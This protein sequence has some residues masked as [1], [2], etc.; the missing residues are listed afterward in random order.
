[1]S[2]LKQPTNI[3]EGFFKDRGSKFHGV[4]F[5]F[6]DP[7]ELKSLL[8]SSHEMFPQ[9]RHYC[10]AYV[11]GIDQLKERAND[12]GEPA[13]SAGTPILNVLR[14]ME[15]TNAL[16]V[17]ARYFGGTKLGVPG[18]IQAYREAAHE[19]AINA[20]KTDAILTDRFNI[21]FDYADK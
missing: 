16:I 4:I 2:L 10:F 14:S 11:I 17:V 8:E 1:M 7:I 13:H 18:L 3:A 19:A 5:P 21:T 15:L 9:A 6:S 20:S 12:D